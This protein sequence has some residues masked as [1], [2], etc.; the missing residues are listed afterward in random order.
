[1]NVTDGF[2]RI[3]AGVGGLN[4]KVCFVEIGAVGSSVDQA[5]IDRVKKAAADATKATGYPRPARPPEVKRLVYGDYV[6]ELVSYTVQKPRHVGRR[7]FVHNNHLYSPQAVTDVGGAVVERYTY[8]AYGRQAVMSGG[9][10]GLTQSAMGMTKGFT[11]QSVDP[12]TGLMYFRARMYSTG[13]GR[14]ISRDQCMRRPIEKNNTP[15]RNRATREIEF[16][17][18]GPSSGDGYHDGLSFYSGYFIPNALDPMGAAVTW[19]YTP[20]AST[21]GC[22]IHRGVIHWGTD[23]E[24]VCRGAGTTPW[25]NEVRGCLDAAARFGIDPLRAHLDCYAEATSIHGVAAAAYSVNDIRTRLRSCRV[26]LWCKLLP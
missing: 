25:D 20:T 5:T 21:V 22:G 16:I 11:G 2:L 26:S 17:L 1:V 12:E 6:D 18:W 7:Y 10:A 19:P 14:F 3:Q 24:C 23:A 9:G 15:R 13:M 4:P 8:D